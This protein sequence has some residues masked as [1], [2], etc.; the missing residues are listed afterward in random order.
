MAD[1]KTRLAPVERGGKCALAMACP[2]GGVP[3]DNYCAVPMA[4]VS[5]FDYLR[6]AMLSLFERHR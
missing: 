2:S 6:E 1:P 4:L 3:A 5:P